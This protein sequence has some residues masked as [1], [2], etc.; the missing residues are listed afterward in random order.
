MWI[1]IFFLAGVATVKNVETDTRN[2]KTG[3]FSADLNAC[4]LYT[5]Q[6][7]Y[8]LIGWRE[9]FVAQPQARA[10]KWATQMGNAQLQCWVAIFLAPPNA[11]NELTAKGTNN[12]EK[13]KVN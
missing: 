11:N 1:G 10:K 7:E 3:T 2:Q 12:E 4:P 13:E 6:L 5:C 9:Q 8:K